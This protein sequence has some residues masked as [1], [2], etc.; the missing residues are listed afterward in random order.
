MAVDAAGTRVGGITVVA[1]VGNATTGLVAVV[2][3]EAKVD[4]GAV[5]R[6]MTMLA[7]ARSATGG[8]STASGKEET[9]REIFASA[10]RSGEE[11]DSR[12]ATEAKGAGGSA[13]APGVGEADAGAKIRSLAWLGVFRSKKGVGAAVAAMVGV[14]ERSESTEGVA[15]G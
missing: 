8:G 3:V 4:G 13:R 15:A 9:A 2:V 11:V 14:E 7:R 10:A 12:G 5:E 6:R 1:P